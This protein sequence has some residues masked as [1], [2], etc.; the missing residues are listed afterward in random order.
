M[1]IATIA[2]T[3]T[4]ITRSEIRLIITFPTFPS[5]RTRRAYAEARLPINGSILTIVHKR[6]AASATYLVG[7]ASAGINCLYCGKPTPCR[8]QHRCPHDRSHPAP[9]P[10]NNRRHTGRLEPGTAGLLAFRRN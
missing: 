7:G 8:A 5:C 10:D 9:V 2:T 1:M 4:Q 6:A 3:P